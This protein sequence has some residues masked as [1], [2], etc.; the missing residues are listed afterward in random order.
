MDC[1]S[2]ILH[3]WAMR[4]VGHWPGK[5]ISSAELTGRLDEWARRDKSIFLFD[6]KDGKVFAS[7]DPSE[8]VT[9]ADPA[10][11]ALNY[12]EFLQDVVK[13]YCPD[14]HTKIAIYLADRGV[15]DTDVP[16]FSFQKPHDS[17]A[18]LMPDIDLLVGGFDTIA[19]FRDPFAYMDKSC[20][21]AFAGSTTG[22]MI[23]EQTALDMSLP[24]L[25]S[26]MFFRDHPAVDFRLPAIVQ[27]NAVAAEILRGK[28]IG[29]G[30][31]VPWR[32]QCRHRFLISMDSNGAAMFACL[33]VSTK[34]QRA[35]E[36]RFAT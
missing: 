7:T 23:N 8:R 30:V 25:R 9:G 11:R 10:A 28:G 20:S 22:A 29:D 16:I 17:H 13:N 32:D 27:A 19:G 2:G 34:Q 21:A 14:L 26:A 5:T 35:A 3:G 31:T 18:L 4:Q 1:T 15:P 33:V 12:L 36:I 24:R 6:I